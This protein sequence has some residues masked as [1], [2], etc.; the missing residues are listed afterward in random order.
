LESTR[1]LVRDEI[2]AMRSLC[3]RNSRREGEKTLPTTPGLFGGLQPRGLARFAPAFDFWFANL[4]VA[5]RLIL[6][7]TLVFK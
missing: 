1:D 6:P 7:E 4:L 3:C 2:L 5:E